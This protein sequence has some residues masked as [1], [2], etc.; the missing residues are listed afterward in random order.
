MPLRSN[1]K[2][3]HTYHKSYSW[4]NGG[5]GSC[6][7]SIRGWVEIT[8]NRHSL[9]TSIIYYIMLYIINIIVLLFRECKN[10][11]TIVENRMVVPHKIANRFFIWT[12]ILEIFVHPC[13]QQHISKSLKGRSN[14][15]VYQGFVDKQS[16]VCAYNRIFRCKNKENSDTCYSIMNPELIMLR[17]LNQS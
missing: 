7:N 3:K 13:P 17:K 9:L 4:K 2:R 16:E 15:T 5:S 8:L 11:A 10:S 6:L 1:Y 14:P 12:A